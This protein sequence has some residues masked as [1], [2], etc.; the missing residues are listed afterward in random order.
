M[1][2]TPADNRNVVADRLAIFSLLLCYGWSFAMILC[3]I[4]VTSNSTDGSTEYVF[5]VLSS[6]LDLPNHLKI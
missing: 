4:T 2:A 5:E 1:E 3:E 6:E